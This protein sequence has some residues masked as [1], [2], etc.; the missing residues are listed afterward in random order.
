M[1]FKPGDTVE[2]KLEVEILQW[3]GLDSVQVSI[4][5]GDIHLWI[6]TDQVMGKVEG[7]NV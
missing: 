5:D 3:D 2:V 4:N 1:N 7:N 6:N